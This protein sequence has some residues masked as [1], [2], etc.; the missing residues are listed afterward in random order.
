MFEQGISK[1][2]RQH[3][4]ILKDASLPVKF[5]LGGGTACALHLGHRLSYDLDF[6][7]DKS[8][9]TKKVLDVL[10]PHGKF[11]FIAQPEIK[12]FFEGKAAGLL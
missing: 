12:R 6:F 8:F 5:Y 11:S 1:K 3:L 9:D 10:K 2:A 4:A 7:S